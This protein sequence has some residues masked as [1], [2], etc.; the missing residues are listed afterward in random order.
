MEAERHSGR[1]LLSTRRAAD[2]PPPRI[3]VLQPADLQMPRDA[4]TCAAVRALAIPFLNRP[5]AGLAGQ[6]DVMLRP[7][8]RAVVDHLRHNA[9]A[10]R[11]SLLTRE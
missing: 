2:T 9:L 8:V 1:Y 11:A 3:Q 6:I 10:P 7:A 4:H 5:T